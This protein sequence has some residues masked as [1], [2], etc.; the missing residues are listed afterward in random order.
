MPAFE[1]RTVRVCVFKS[2]HKSKVGQNMELIRSEREQAHE[3]EHNYERS[4]DPKFL[5]YLSHSV[6]RSFSPSGVSG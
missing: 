4:E 2:Q 3:D 5:F 6:F 1:V